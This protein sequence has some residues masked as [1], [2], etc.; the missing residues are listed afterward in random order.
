MELN[1][2]I[3]K[4]YDIR[5][6]YP[7]QLNSEIVQQ[8]IPAYIIYLIRKSNKK[9]DELKVVVGWD[10]RIGNDE[11][12][13][14]AL[15]IMQ[16][17]GVQIITVG[18]VP[19]DYIYFSTGRYNFDGGL[20]FT[21]SHNPKEYLG[22]KMLSLNVEPV[23]GRELLK[24]IESGEMI[25]SEIKGTVTEQDYWQAFINHIQAFV[26]INNIKPLKIVVDAGNGLAGLVI[27]RLLGKSRL[28]IEPLFYELDGNFPNR[29]SNPLAVEGQKPCR[30]KIKEVKADLG[31]MFD[32]DTDRMFLMDEKGNLVRGDMILLLIARSMIKLNPGAGIV[33]N[34]ICSHA[35]P[36]M[37]TKWGGQPIRSEVGYSN[38]AKNMKLK[39]GI[40][41]GE[42]SAHFAFADNYYA[43]SGFIGLLLALKA[44]S[45]DGRKLSEIIKEFSLYVRGDEINLTV[46]SVP[47]NLEKI[48]NHYKANIKDEIDGITVEFPDWWFNARPSNTEPLLRITVEARNEKELKK[49]Q[50]EILKV[51]KN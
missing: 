51:I 4:S 8:I 38:L 19:I 22:M 40:M 14:T 43:D 37:I 28:Q 3:F 9:P 25:S 47:E 30:E 42:V 2:K 32:G 45:D 21:A 50:A 1:K 41:S 33:Y 34:L 13:Q 11:L 35:V 39:N 27:P 24:I 16:N 15:E 26:D 49:H 5:G 23:S 29:P 18:L 36:E 48:R 17:L 20:M 7:D 31:V 12:V 44:I 6:T 10:M 46:D